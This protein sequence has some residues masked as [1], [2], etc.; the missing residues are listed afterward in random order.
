MSKV[1]RVTAHPSDDKKVAT[2]T[3][4]IGKKSHTVTV[5]ANVELHQGYSPWLP[6]AT[7]TAMGRGFNLELCGPV[8][9]R[10]LAG[11]HKAQEVLNSW[12][13][14]ELSKVSVAALDTY[15]AEPELSR[16]VGCFFSGGVDSFYSAIQHSDEI[17]HLILVHG[18]DISLS[19]M[20]RWEETLNH[21][22]A[23]AKEMG[24]SLI[25]V[26]SDLRVLHA[27]FGP[28]WQRHAHGAFLANIGH[29]L[30]SK[31]RKVIIPSSHD[32]ATLRPIGTHPDL[33]PLW[34]SARLEI[35]H[36][37]IDANRTDKLEVL[38][39]HDVVMDHL[40]VCWAN[41]AEGYNCGNCEKCI[42][43]MISLKVVGALERCNTFPD[44]VPIERIK[45]LYLH[46]AGPGGYHFAEENLRI[47]RERGVDDPELIEALEYAVNRGVLENFQ[48]KMRFFAVDVGY[49]LARFYAR[50][51][52]RS[53]RN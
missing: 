15:R 2:A 53:I 32:R 42:R 14:D 1:L 24:K 5:S 23:I 9:D 10:V 49:Y 19:N 38:R 48:V 13:A 51:L 47:L 41:L 26:Q 20:E 6:P 28:H 4:D 18:L 12:H 45:K 30:S 3:F 44:T 33:D 34:S 16:G 7:L 27:K 8:E 11:A 29:L 17:T 21:V 35:V 31:L 25:E 43:T 36:D 52:L 50:N 37:D 22:R 46:A 39:H 40:R